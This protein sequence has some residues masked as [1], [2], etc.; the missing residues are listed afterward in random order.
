MK[1]VI[2]TVAAGWLMVALC[3]CAGAYVAGD[4]GADHGAIDAHRG[5][6]A[7]PSRP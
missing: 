7:A 1:R 2:A 6:L 3:G 4:V 5:N